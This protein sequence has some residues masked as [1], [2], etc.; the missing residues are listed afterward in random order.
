MNEVLGVFDLGIPIIHFLF[1]LLVIFVIFC[2]CYIKQG[3]IYKG[4]LLILL[5]VIYIYVLAGSTIV[6]RD[7]WYLSLNWVRRYEMIPF[8]SYYEA[9]TK[10]QYILM[11][12]CL[13][14]VILFIPFGLLLNAILKPKSMARIITSAFLL[15]F[16]IE[17]L[18]AFTHRGLCEMDDIIHNT[19][20]AW[21][22]CLLLKKIT[23]LWK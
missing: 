22:G 7:S 6:Y 3:Q 17:I 1:V 4:Q 10:K 5:F 16:V 20:G 21:L 11:L 2:V 23:I 14:N 19:V 8:R 18:Q 13:L 15:S 9:I 12:Q